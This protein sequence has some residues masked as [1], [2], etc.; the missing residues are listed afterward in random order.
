MKKKSILL[1]LPTELVLLIELKEKCYDI[2][3]IGDSRKLKEASE[4][5]DT[6]LV[7]FKAKDLSFTSVCNCALYHAVKNKND[8]LAE[9]ILFNMKK[10]GKKEMERLLKLI[11]L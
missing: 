5:F 8:I 6:L 11:T 9:Q 2:K 4:M 7:R 10:H 1:Q 3:K